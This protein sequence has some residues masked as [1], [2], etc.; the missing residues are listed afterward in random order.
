MDFKIVLTIAISTPLTAGVLMLGLYKIKGKAKASIGPDGKLSLE[1]GETPARRETDSPEW[2]ERFASRIIE[3][4]RSG[5]AHDCAQADL[6]RVMAD[7]HEKHTDA[8]I[9]VTEVAKDHG[10]NGDTQ[11]IHDEQVEHKKEFHEVVIERAFPR[12]EVAT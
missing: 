6:V 2:S 4:V 11:K 12:R 8:I 5:L 1:V 3:A 9:R 10:W 7:G